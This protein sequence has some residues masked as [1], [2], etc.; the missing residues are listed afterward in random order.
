[1]VKKSTPKTDAAKAKFDKA[2]D[3]FVYGNGSFSDAEKAATELAYA[4]NEEGTWT[5][6]GP[7]PSPNSY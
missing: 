3:D 2:A 1:M 4:Q 5:T 7:Y 6:Y